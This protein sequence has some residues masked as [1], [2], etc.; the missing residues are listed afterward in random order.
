[1]CWLMRVNTY[2]GRLTG[3]DEPAY[4]V[5]PASYQLVYQDKLRYHDVTLI[6]GR[7]TILS[8]P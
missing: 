3:H 1:M 8:S 2:N 4:R 6:A 7:S 5:V